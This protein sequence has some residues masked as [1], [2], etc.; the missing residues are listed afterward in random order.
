MQDYLLIKQKQ[1]F[2][3]ILFFPTTF[4]SPSLQQPCCKS[5]KPLQLKDKNKT[6][7]QPDYNKMK[8]VNDTDYPEQEVPSA[9]QSHSLVTF[10]GLS[11]KV[12]RLSAGTD[13]LDP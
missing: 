13:D 8:F 7:T 2:D 6:R 4:S 5:G 9:A 11:K 3:V 10:L 12:N 1:G